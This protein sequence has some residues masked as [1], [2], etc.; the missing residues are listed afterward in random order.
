MKSQQVIFFFGNTQS[1]KYRQCIN[2]N[3]I[4]QLLVFTEINQHLETFRQHYFQLLFER[5]IL[6]TQ[7]RARKIKSDEKII[8]FKE[9]IG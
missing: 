7:R 1:S 4:C 8:N 6:R 5:G 3:T 2:Y 9:E